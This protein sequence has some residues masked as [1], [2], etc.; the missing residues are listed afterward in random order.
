MTNRIDILVLADRDAKALWPL[1]EIEPPPLLPMG[2]KP[3]V[4]HVIEA[5]ATRVDATVTVVVAAGDTRTPAHLASRGFPRLKIVVTDRPVPVV[6][7]PTIVLRGDIVAS[8]ADIHA[9]LDNPSARDEPLRGAWR[10][11]AGARTPTWRH[12]AMLANHSDRMLPTV[13]AFWRMSIAA[14]KGAV[15]GLEL[16]GWL[17]SDGLRVGLDARVMTRRAPGE[18]AM[19]GARAFVDKLVALGDGAIVGDD[20]YIGKGARLRDAVVMPRSYVGPGLE[21]TGVVVAGGWLWRADTG[22]ATRAPDA[23]LI[24]ALA[25]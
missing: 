22:E 2:G 8:Q 6:D 4:D 18:G 5:L 12:T 7:K 1:T 17:E 13:A 21:L 20:C 25:A 24:G 3:L 19:V 14:G 15:E 9:F 10:L 16:A 23:K 11:P